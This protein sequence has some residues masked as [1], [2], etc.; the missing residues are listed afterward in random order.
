MTA[1]QHASGVL[2][3]DLVTL[4]RPAICQTE[5]IDPHV[6]GVGTRAGLINSFQCFSRRPHRSLPERGA[7]PTGGVEGAC[8][9]MGVS[10]DSYN[11]RPEELLVNARTADVRFREIAVRC[12]AV[13][14]GGR[15][16]ASH[17]DWHQAV[18]GQGNGLEP[19]RLLYDGLPPLGLQEA[20]RA[21]PATA[22]L[23]LEL[24]VPT[25]FRR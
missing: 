8:P 2:N 20:V 5:A 3:D 19:E 1:I 14:D 24:A 17:A 9:S 21:A 4:D 12:A 6:E 13:A 18:A 16:R 25:R 22:S 15:R 11:A 23:P 7:P 10:S